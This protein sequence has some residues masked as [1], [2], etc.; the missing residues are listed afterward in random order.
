MILFTTKKATVIYQLKISLIF[1]LF[2]QA[3]FAAEELANFCF[4]PGTDLNAARNSL[5]F[6]LLP[7]EKT[8]LRTEQR[9]MDVLTST[10]RVKLL[11]KYLRLRYTLVDED[12]PARNVVKLQEENCRMELKKTIDNKAGINDVNIGQVNT[13]TTGQLNKATSETSELLLSFGK[14]AALSIGLQAIFV[15]CRKGAKDNFNITFAL[16]ENGGATRIATDVTVKQN[17]MIDVGQ[18]TK[19]LNEKQRILG[20]P[21]TT[22]NTYLGTEV[23]TY[24]L[25]VTN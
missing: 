19:N 23:T 18:I 6:L 22:V 17:E 1:I 13:V 5:G 4:Q 3:L 14:P 25:K 9:C 24:Q 7:S 8:F 11:E 20:Y 16:S 2:S 15:E 21:Q 12:T 10:D